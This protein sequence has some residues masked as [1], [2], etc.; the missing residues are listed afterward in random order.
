MTSTYQD[1]AKRSFRYFGLL[2]RRTLNNIK[3]SLGLL[4]PNR[5]FRKFGMN[6]IINVTIIVVTFTSQGRIQDFS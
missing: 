2:L 6:S 4:T 1:Y 5:S 3:N